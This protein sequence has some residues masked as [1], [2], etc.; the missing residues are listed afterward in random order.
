MSRIK[1]EKDSA[2]ITFGKN[3]LPGK[4]DHLK[5]DLLSLAAEG[6]KSIR[7][8]FK[9][10]KSIDLTLITLLIAAQNTFLQGGGR[11]ALMNC[12]EN[13]LENLGKLN[14]AEFLCLADAE[15]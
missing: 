5:K 1:R 11:I 12:P 8:D 9:K 3:D 15:N 7:L 4:R 10:V 2:I 6:L 14:L 13:I